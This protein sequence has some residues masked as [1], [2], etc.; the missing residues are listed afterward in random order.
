MAPAILI[1]G[2]PDREA[3]WN[4]DRYACDGSFAG[5]TWHPSWADALYQIQFEYESDLIFEPVPKD[6]TD[7]R[8]YAGALAARG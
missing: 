3:G 7:P 5:N 8:K 6:A 2:R 1:L 4:L